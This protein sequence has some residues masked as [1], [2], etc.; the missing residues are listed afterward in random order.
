MAMKPDRIAALR[1]WLPVVER[2]SPEELG[3]VHGARFDFR[4][5]AYEMRLAGI[6]G[7]ATSG[8]EAAKES[9]LRAARRKVARAEDE[10]EG[11]VAA[12]GDPKTCRWCGM[13]IDDLRP[14]DEAE[15]RS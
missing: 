6:S 8:R 1:A 10:C 7:T 5:G 14:E 13:Q 2:S 11:H 15:G 9:W 4:A 12:D 3:M